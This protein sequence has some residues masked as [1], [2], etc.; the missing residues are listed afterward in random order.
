LQERPATFEI[1]EAHTRV[2]AVRLSPLG[3][4]RLI[5]GVPQAELTG[6]VLDGE[7]V[8]GG[9]AGISALC[10]R[11]KNA[12]DLG[13]ALDWL[14]DWLAERF[15]GSRPAH[16][17]GSRLH[18]ARGQLRVDELAGAAAVSP[19]RLHELFVREIGVPPKRLARILRFRAA[20]ERLAT[21]PA[22][23]LTRLALDCG[24]YDQA[25]L[26]RD[27]RALSTMTPVDYLTARGVG[28]DGF[29]VLGS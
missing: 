9:S 26:Y 3:G 23:D 25:H 16:A 5:G 19:R 22:V 4:W 20:L 12:P 13:G 18:D 17:A 7:A 11:M 21:A 8:L 15:T 14:E 28:L 24:Y 29:D 27:F 10:E 6:R 1:F 2:T